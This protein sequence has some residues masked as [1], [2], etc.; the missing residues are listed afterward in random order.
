MASKDTSIEM[1]SSRSLST[2]GRVQ[3]MHAASTVASK[4]S[5]RGCERK[6][7]F[8]GSHKRSTRFNS[9]EYGG[10]SDSVTLVGTSKPPDQ[11]QPACSST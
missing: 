10:K 7:A 3:A 8:G 2:L 1:W 6:R 4:P 9:G 5:C 11:C